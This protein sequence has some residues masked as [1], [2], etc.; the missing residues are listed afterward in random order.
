SGGR[1]AQAGAADRGRR[2]HRRRSAPAARPGAGR[3][4]RRAPGRQMAAPHRRG[5]ALARP[6]EHPRR[7]VA[8]RRRA[9]PA[10]GGRLAL[11][12][13]EAGGRSG[14]AGHRR[15][16]PRRGARAMTALR[17]ARLVAAFLLGA[18][19]L[20]AAGPARSHE[21]DSALLSLKEVDSGRFQVYWHA[22]SRTLQDDLG[23]AVVFPPACHLRGDLLDCGP[24][25]LVGAIAFPWIEGTLT[26]VVVDVQWRGGAHFLRIATPTAPSLKVY[27]ASAAGW[28]AL[29][30]IAADYTALGVEHILT[31]FD[32]LL[33]VVA[34]TL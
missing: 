31:G 34:L 12:R 32:H 19:V 30:P 29:A 6:A 27:G 26:R 24:S 25:G 18:A 9:A 28:R 4:H 17:C 23:A 10:P 3:R 8:E 13:A 20:L 21:I 15:P 7:R 14:R 2:P 11:R 16:L 5:R 22:A 1:P 33:F